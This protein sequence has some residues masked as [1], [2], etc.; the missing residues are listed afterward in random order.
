MTRI[1][2]LTSS[3]IEVFKFFSAIMAS[4]RL[5]VKVGI[6]FRAVLVLIR[7]WKASEVIQVAIVFGVQAV[8][9]NVHG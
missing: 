4:L 3:V 8:A 7:N 2:V 6:V 9:I 1:A 5:L